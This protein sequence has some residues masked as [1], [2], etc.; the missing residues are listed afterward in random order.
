M[1][2]Q[3]NKLLEFKRCLTLFS[4]ICGM[5]KKTI[6]L[7]TIIT[8][9]S[10]VALIMLQ[11][12][13]FREVYDMRQE[14]FDA[15]V[16]RSLWRASR[17]LELDETRSRLEK[18]MMVLDS[19]DDAPMRDKLVQRFHALPVR[20]LINESMKVTSPNFRDSVE[21]LV[22]RKELAKDVVYSVLYTS[23]NVELADRIDFVRL[24]GY[25]RRT[26]ENNGI[27]LSYHFTVSTAYG[28][29]IYRCADF[30]APKPGT[31]T[32][33]QTLFPADPQAYMGTLNVY[34]PDIRP[35]LLGDIRYMVP[36]MMFT[37]LL[38]V[39]FVFAIVVILRQRHLSDVKNNF[40][41]NMTHEF[42]TPISTI[43]LAAQMLSDP[44]VS[45]SEAMLQ[46][47]CRVIADETKRLR[48]QV[49]KVLQMSV[50]DRKAI[51]FKQQELDVH[52]VVNDVVTVFRLKVESLG[53]QIK[54]DLNALNS[55]V[56]VDEMHFTNVLFNLMDNAVKYRSEER[57]LQLTISTK[58]KD[59]HIVIGVRDNGIGIKREHLKHIFGRF[60]RI[61]TG[62]R[63]DV[64]G[65]GLGL[66]YVKSVVKNLN[67]TI[68]AESEYGEGTEF[69]I[70]LPNQKPADE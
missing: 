56:L 67:G 9:I 17:Q 25:L 66:A 68:H 20:D 40:I 18:K 61:N 70:I 47:V 39:I 36:A 53:G 37:I 5:K 8:A 6:W 7:L 49:E 51:A 69:V 28:E 14:Q 55:H 60:Y 26:L 23:S 57:P 62:N 33:S 22:Y 59:K 1:F 58:N 29:E 54:T 34:F 15:T 43:S 12:R 46:H 38:L 30:V 3:L 50:F 41:N 13:Y 4:Y 32:Y 65:F 35:Y 64:K 24:D 16:K 11:T 42:K 19:I 52:N 10:F 2:S 45:K 27:N 31:P 21:S 63:H 44:S 48:F